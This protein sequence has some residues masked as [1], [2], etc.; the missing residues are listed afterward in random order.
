MSIQSGNFYVNFK[1]TFLLSLFISYLQSIEILRILLG[2]NQI[3][4]E[5]LL[6]AT[7]IVKYLSSLDAE[8]K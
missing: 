7:E 2:M 8:K 4:F 1:V 5:Y 3:D 6:V